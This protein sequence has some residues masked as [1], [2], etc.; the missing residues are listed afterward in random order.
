MRVE[1]IVGSMIVLPSSM[2]FDQD[3]VRF[4][5]VFIGA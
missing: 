1:F 2:L 5:Y 3:F 4:F